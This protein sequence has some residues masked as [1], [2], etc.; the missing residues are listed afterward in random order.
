[1]KVVWTGRARARL[2]QIYNYIAQ[3]QPLNAE[4]VV[5]RITLRARQLN[6]QPRSGRMVDDYQREDIRELI[7]RG[8][9]DLEAGRTYTSEALLESLGLAE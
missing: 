2:R 5:D 9:A 3:D 8:L 7:E 4:R 6:E 1:M